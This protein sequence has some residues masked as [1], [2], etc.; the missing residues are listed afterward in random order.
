MCGG[1]RVPGCVVGRECP[2]VWW[3]ESGRVCDGE[4]VARRWISQYTSS[5]MQ[6]SSD[7][8]EAGSELLQLFFRDS[9]SVPEQTQ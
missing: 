2:G 8:P 9:N 6:R 7:S 1:E 5:S 4:R 3:G